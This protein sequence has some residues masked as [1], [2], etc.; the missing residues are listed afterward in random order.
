MS[1][2]RLLVAVLSG[3]AACVA[4]VIFGEA[5]IRIAGHQV[6]R[7]IAS[8][9]P[10]TGWRQTFAMVFDFLARYFAIMSPLILLACVSGALFL[11][12]MMSRHAAA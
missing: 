6:V 5:A 10:L 7:W 1:G 4:L 11:A 2:R 3:V 8:G 12:G 9:V